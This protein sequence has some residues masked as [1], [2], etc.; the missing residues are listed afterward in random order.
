MLRA[1][2]GLKT[3]P[4]LW[5]KHITRTLEDLGLH[6]ILDSNYLFVNDWLIL[7]F[8]VDD[9]IIAYAPRDQPLMDKFEVDL[10]NKYEMRRMGEAEHFLEV[11]IIQDRP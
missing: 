6:S 9:I 8:Y 4:L 1:I 5:Y 7:I 10:L 11:R 2:Y 3:S